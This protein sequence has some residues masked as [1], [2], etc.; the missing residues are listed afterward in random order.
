MASWR[1]YPA[2]SS[3]RCSPGSSPM[4][5]DTRAGLPGRCP[6]KGVHNT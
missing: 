2:G 1:G 5:D 6:L 4:F 3:W